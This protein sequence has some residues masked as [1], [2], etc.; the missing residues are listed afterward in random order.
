MLRQEFTRYMVLRPSGTPSFLI[1][2]QIFA[3]EPLPSSRNYCLLLPF[4]AAFRAAAFC[5]RTSAAF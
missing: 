4:E 1:S 3:E 5:E 2:G